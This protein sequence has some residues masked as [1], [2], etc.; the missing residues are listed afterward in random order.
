MVFEGDLYRIPE[1]SERQ[2]QG[3]LSELL[4]GML[5]ETLKGHGLSQSSE[6]KYRHF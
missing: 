2:I 6:N 1:A 4:G 3:H 5:L